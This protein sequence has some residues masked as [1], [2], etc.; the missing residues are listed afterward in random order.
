M[1]TSRT[2]AH[3]QYRRAIP[4]AVLVVCSQFA[5]A[6]QVGSI[7]LEGAASV[8]VKGPHVSDVSLPNAPAPVLNLKDEG[9]TDADTPLQDKPHPPVTYVDIPRHF[10]PDEAHIFAGPAFLRK[11]DLKWLLPLAGATAV[12]LST[13]TYT[14][15]HVV[16]RDASFNHSNDQ[17]STILRDSFIGMPVV[18]AGLGQA[19]HDD[20]LRESGLLGGEAMLDAYVFDEIVKISSWRERP[21]VDNARGE[22][23]VG[24]AGTNSSF[25]SGHSIIAWSSAAVLAGEYPS[26]WHETIAYTLASGVSLTRVLAQKH[27][28]SDVLVG[29]AT[30]WLIGHYIFRAHHHAFRKAAAHHDSLAQAMSKLTPWA[31]G[32]S[33]P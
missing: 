2:L 24:S 14:M 4:I 16:S 33:D 9:Q 13:D 11:R 29:G 5:Y 8:P 28:P 3:F 31:S 22:F 18:F 30:G 21:D 12:A 32:R 26:K 25:V 6:G 15:R 10:L 7:D 20:H 27:F 1:N 23:F 17:A 19:S